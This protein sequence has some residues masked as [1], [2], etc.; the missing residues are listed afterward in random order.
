MRA[1]L[2]DLCLCS[3][4]TLRAPD[5]LLSSVTE[6]KHLNPPQPEHL[7]TATSAEIHLMQ[8]HA[9]SVSHPVSI[10]G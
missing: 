2:D 8:H 10:H 4:H 5:L 3:I 7:K 9:S 1:W 6:A